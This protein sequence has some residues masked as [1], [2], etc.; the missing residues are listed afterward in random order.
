MKKL[1]FTLF[2]PV[3]LLAQEK[4]LT[5]GFMP[6][7][8][9]SV[10][11]QKY[12]PLAEYLSKELGRDVKIVIAKDYTSHIQNCGEDRLDIAFLGGSPYTVIT[13]DYGEKPLL[14]RYEFEGNPTFRSVVVTSESSPLSSLEEL[15]GKRFAF[16]N[17]NSTLSTQVP[18]FMLHQAGIA[19]EDLKAYIHMRNHENVVMGTIFGD[20]DAGAV[21][22]EVYREKRHEGLKALAFSPPLSTH[23]FVT[24]A[25]MPKP[26][27]QKIRQALLQ[28]DDPR[29]LHAISNKLTGFVPVKDSDYDYHRSMLQTVL[30]LL[31]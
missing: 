6:Y 14:A 12:T 21:A 15:Q 18:L 1:L 20:F 3:L 16:G 24:A 11:L 10:L 29:I 19:L 23:L 13:E 22:E 28:L 27:R 7:L 26:L 4:A 17:K 25:T 5:L 31:E 2:F 9:S 8:S 30:P